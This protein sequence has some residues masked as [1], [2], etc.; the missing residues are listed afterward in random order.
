MEIKYFGHCCFQ[1]RGKNVV[2][3]TNPLD[4]SL[5][6]KLPNLTADVVILGDNEKAEEVLKIKAANR[7]TPFFIDEAGEYEVGGAFILGISSGKNTLY[8]IT[9]DGL[10]LVF[11]GN[12]FDKLSEKQ[13]EEVDGVDILF[14]PVGG[15]LVLSSKQAAEI[16]GQIEPKIIIPM[17]YKVPHLNLDL[18]P[19]DDFLRE[20]GM[21]E[22]KPLEKLIISKDKLPLDSKE[23]VVLSAKD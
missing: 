3:L 18:A 10:R 12:Q 15:K 9:V 19:V 23:V 2:L 7:E 4:S 22:V 1:I 5:G 21:E 14:L 13:L 17:A 11:L 6:I 20:M 8:V 16:V